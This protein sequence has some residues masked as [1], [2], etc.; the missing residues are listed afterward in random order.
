MRDGENVDSSRGKGKA[1]DYYIVDPFP[2]NLLSVHFR[3][4]FPRAIG[5]QPALFKLDVASVVKT[6]H[7]PS[8]FTDQSPLLKTSQQMAGLPCD[9]AGSLK[10]QG[11]LDKGSSTD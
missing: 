6:A 9:K 10:L 3:C 11:L 2:G 7:I 4:T 8:R 1:L 5:N